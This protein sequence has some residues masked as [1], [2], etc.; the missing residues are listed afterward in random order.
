MRPKEHDQATFGLIA[1]RAFSDLL[2]Q[3]CGESNYVFVPDMI[4]VPAGLP[5][6]PIKEK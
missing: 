5:L 2:F 6:L 4:L 3:Q 1:S